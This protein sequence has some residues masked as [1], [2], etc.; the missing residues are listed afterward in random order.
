MSN[1]YSSKLVLSLNVTFVDS[2]RMEKNTAD[3]FTSR[4]GEL[5][6]TDRTER[7]LMLD[8]STAVGASLKMSTDS[9]LKHSVERK[10]EPF[11]A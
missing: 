7:C 10:L 5:N 1:S 11:V 2:Q 9:A 4:L 6:R 3:S 8:N